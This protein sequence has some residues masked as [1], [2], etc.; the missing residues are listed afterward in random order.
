MEIT[1]IDVNFAPIAPI[2]EP[3]LA[4][5]S[6]TSLFDTVVSELGRVNDKLVNAS[7]ELR[8]V[9]TGDAKNL[10]GAMIAL[11]GAKL[12]FQLLLQVRNRF[13]EAYQELMRM[14]V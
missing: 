9:A 5:S 8:K 1:P 7:D 12:E 14:Q 3:K 6:E 4:G 11:E 10:H 13:M 2:T